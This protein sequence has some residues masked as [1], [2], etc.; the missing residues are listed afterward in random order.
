[1]VFSLLKGCN[2][3]MLAFACIFMHISLCTM[4]DFHV[5]GKN[6]G[7]LEAAVDGGIAQPVFCS[8][9]SLPEIPFWPCYFAAMMAGGSWFL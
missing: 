2:W 4:Q 9:R 5:S 6:R 7:C 1:M 3:E 8:A